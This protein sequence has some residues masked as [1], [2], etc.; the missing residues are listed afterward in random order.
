MRLLLHSVS[1]STRGTEQGGSIGRSNKT[2][3]PMQHVD[4]ALPTL[5]M[6]SNVDFGY[7]ALEWHDNKASNSAITK[8][9]RST[10]TQGIAT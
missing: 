7:I 4:N 10:S 2:R 6:A 9:N 8:A 5:G 1:T 3:E